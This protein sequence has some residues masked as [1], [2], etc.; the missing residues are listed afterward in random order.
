MKMLNLALECE[1][2]PAYA[3]ARLNSLA[4]N[5]SFVK[6]GGRSIALKAFLGLLFID[7]RVQ[8]ISQYLLILRQHVDKLESIP[9]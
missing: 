6:C 7:G 1:D 8:I 2:K 3:P 9:V 5:T 4:E